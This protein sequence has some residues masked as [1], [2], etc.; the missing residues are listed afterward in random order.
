MSIHRLLL[1]FLIM[2]PIATSFPVAAAAR[3]AVPASVA[4]RTA[5]DEHFLTGEFK[6][7]DS[8]WRDWV[9]KGKISD[10]T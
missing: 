9:S 8:A 5:L 4:V 6:R 1:S 3:A 10:V 2:T 7:R